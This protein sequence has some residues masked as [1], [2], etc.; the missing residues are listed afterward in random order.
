MDPNLRFARFFLV[1]ALLCGVVARAR[2]EDAAKKQASRPLVPI[3]LRFEGHLALVHAADAGFAPGVGASASV[4]GGPFLLGVGGDLETQVLGYSRGGAALHA[5][6]LAPLKPLELDAVG[7]VGLA[8][9]HDG[10]RL[11]SD[12]PGAG[13]SIVFVGVRGGVRVTVFNSSDA[14]A[15]LALGI[16]GSYEHDLNPYT[17]TY[18]YTEHGWLFDNEESVETNTVRIGTERI[19]FMLSVSVSLE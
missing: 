11:L 16:L 4:V 10:P 6:L 18:E 17:V 19:A 12:N 13:G 1:A 15:H 14:M 2:A 7:V 8:Y 3:P 5:G 9:T